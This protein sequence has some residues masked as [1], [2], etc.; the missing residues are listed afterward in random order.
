MSARRRAGA[1]L[2]PWLLWGLSTACVEPEPQ[3]VPMYV[4]LAVG[5][6]PLTSSQGEPKIGL[7][8][9]RDQVRHAV[10]LRAG[11][12]L[13]AQLELGA[14]P[15]LHLH[16]CLRRV[17]AGSAGD[18]R[19][20]LEHRAGTR[21]PAEVSLDLPPRGWWRHEEALPGLESGSSTLELALEGAEAGDEVVLQDLYVRHLV[22]PPSPLSASARRI[23]LVSLDTLREDAVAAL[24]PAGARARAATP[25]LDALVGDAE[26]FSPHYA[27]ASWTKP[28]HASMLT[29]RLPAGHG[30]VETEDGIAEGVPLVS[31][32]LRDEGFLTHALTFDHA[33]LAPKWGF[34]RGFEAY[35]MKPWQVGPLVR[36]LHNWLARHRDRDLFVFFHTFEPHSDFRRL[37]YEGP[38]ATTERVARRFGLESYGC[39]EGSCA[40]SL[41]TALGS[42]KLE[43]LPREGAALHFLYDRGVEETDLW[44]G[45]LV[46]GLRELGLYEP[47][48]LLVTSDHGEAFLEGPGRAGHGHNW[49]TVLRV[50]MLVKWPAGE[51]AGTRTEAPSGALDLAPTILAGAGLE[52]PELELRGLRLDRLAASERVRRP[53]FSG[54]KR[55]VVWHDGF[56]LSGTQLELR[57]HDL[58]A[59]PDELVDLGPERPELV[60]ELGELVLRR[61]ALA[62]SVRRGGATR[63]ELTDEER[64]RLQAL[65]YLG[66]QDG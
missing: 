20:R 46:E 24:R 19:L 27:A 11:E 15:R 37:P 59:D 8:G 3:R 65:G 49:D 5:D 47:S 58:D 6:A 9:C 36:R 39:R 17:G 62:A 53:I 2:A 16:G 4:D 26:V 43:A 30:I 57:L 14:Q 21:F 34:S 56:K 42:G 18:V 31:E 66:G 52:L 40:S 32:L 51:R 7:E 33:W 50:P 54:T 38:G 1:V 45:R 55:M 22:S 44:M 10:V 25:A 12:R 61:L 23:L 29:G 63:S 35:D 41:V 64:A 28:S 48:A 13:Q 60:L